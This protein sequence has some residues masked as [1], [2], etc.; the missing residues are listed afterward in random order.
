MDRFAQLPAT[1]RQIYFQQ[2]G[3][4]RN[5]APWVME[6]DFWVCWTLDKLFSLPEISDSLTFKG[7]TSLSKVY[8]LI[9]RFSEDIDV[10]IDRS[11]LGFGGSQSPE[12]A[13]SG[14]ETTRRLEGLSA[15]CQQFISERL[16]GQLRE[17]MQRSLVT[18]EPWSLE[19]DPDDPDQ[20]TILFRYPNAD[21]SQAARYVLP[22]V[23]IEMGARSDRWP[24]EDAPVTPYLAEIF[25]RAFQK[26]S[27]QVH[28]LQPVRTFWEKATILHAEFH[29]ETNKPLRPRLSRHYYDLAQLL[30]HG[31]GQ[32]AAENPEL[33]RHV[34]EHKAVFFRS[35]RAQYDKARKGSLKLTPN[36]SRQQELE[37]DYRDMQEMFFKDPPVF[38]N[39]LQTIEA[40][41]TNFNRDAL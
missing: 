31:I 29:G 12:R 9:D 38:A 11:H 40:F 6:K 8:K 17:S 35:A 19:L 36:L 33:L 39:I 7:G 32:K 21:A 34:A 20:Q 23:K 13:E 5:L 15:A 41:E 18:N 1:E 24:C 10:S 22:M 2:G 14:K 28:V 37:R 16:L 3:T 27:C 30:H 25:H 4:Q 26:P